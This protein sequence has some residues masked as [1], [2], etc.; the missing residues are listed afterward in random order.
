MGGGRPG[1]TLTPGEIAD[2]PGP[3]PNPWLTPQ[4]AVEDPA[5]VADLLRRHSARTMNRAELEHRHEDLQR[6]SPGAGQ[7]DSEALA[8][9]ARADP[10]ETLELLVDLAKATDATIRVAARELARRLSIRPPRVV[11]GDRSGTSRLSTVDDP[12]A[13]VDLDL[14][15]TLAQLDRHPRLRAEDVRVRAWR[16]PATAYVLLVDAS[17]SVAGPRIA[18]ALVTAAAVAARMRPDD[19]L[20]VIA[21]WSQAVVLRPVRS[22]ASTADLVGALLTLRG[23]G[24]T[25]VALALRT[26][27]R[28]AGVAR[29]RRRELVL[30]T[31]GVATAG[32]DPLPVAAAAASAGARLHV[33]GL[34]DESASRLL[35]ARLAGSGGG[36]YADLLRPSQAAAA[37][38]A[39]LRP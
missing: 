10:D 5:E 8:E 4:Q 19:E 12:Y 14:D 29:A 37:V 15:A 35:C 26:G 27:L 39:V 2:L 30:L 34:S 28:Q 31:D 36:R 3:P 38:A 6:F 7:V 23:G 11:D 32:V 16:S 24:T 33:L 20:A 17:G 25:D 1:K 13:G 21:F 22:I 18:T 9:A